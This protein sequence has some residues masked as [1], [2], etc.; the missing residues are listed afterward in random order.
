MRIYRKTQIK[1]NLGNINIF[2]FPSMNENYVF[3]SNFGTSLRL[4]VK[5]YFKF[6]L[7][8]IQNFCNKLG[9]VI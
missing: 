5:N 8:H 3:S 7:I 6:C 2:S 9:E 4:T 1:K